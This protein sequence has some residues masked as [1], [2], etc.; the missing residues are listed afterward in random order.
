MKNHSILAAEKSIEVKWWEKITKK[1]PH[2]GCVVQIE[3]VRRRFKEVSSGCKKS[4]GSFTAYQRC[5]L[6][7]I[8][9]LEDNSNK[10]CTAKSPL[11]DYPK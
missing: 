1:V 3:G 6:A 2:G 8:L 9:L 4:S 11:I 7:D 5:D 10:H